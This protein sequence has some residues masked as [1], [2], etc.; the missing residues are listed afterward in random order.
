MQGRVGHQSC[1]IGIDLGTISVKAIAFDVSMHEISSA[2][3]PI[4]SR[5]DDAGGRIHQYLHYLPNIFLSIR[6]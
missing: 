3:Q 5:H 2:A 4:E 1:A 6:E